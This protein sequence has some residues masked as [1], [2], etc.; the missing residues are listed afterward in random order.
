VHCRK[1]LPDLSAPVASG[2][3]MD[4]SSSLRSYCGLYQLGWEDDCE[5][6]WEE[7]WETYLFLEPASAYDHSL[8]WWTEWS[9]ECSREWWRVRK[10]KRLSKEGIRLDKKSRE[11]KVLF[12]SL[13]TLWGL[14]D[15]IIEL[16]QTV[17]V[18][19]ILILDTFFTGFSEFPNSM[20]PPCTTMPWTIWPALLVLW[21]VCWMF[22]TPLS[23]ADEHQL[24]LSLL[25]EWAPFPNAGT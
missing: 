12:D 18:H 10:V 19:I 4:T 17:R 14:L 11:L 9:R 22:Y 15:T 1:L 21:G 3:I 2:S 7:G 23:P 16:M 6:D 8:D 13:R 24:N 5:D 25:D 20:R